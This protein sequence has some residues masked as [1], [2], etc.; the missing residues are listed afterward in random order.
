MTARK[1]L[2]VLA[3]MTTLVLSVCVLLLV[4]PW[5]DY[6][7]L[8]MNS[9]FHPDQRA[10]NFR[11]MERIFPSRVIAASTT[12][13][14]FARDEKPLAV[15]YRF[16][17][18]DYTLDDARQRL[19][20]T[21]LLV[22]KDD[23]IVHEG[24]WQGADADS[25]FTSWSVAK[26]FVATL[27]GMALAEGRIRSL[28]DPISD[29][30]P[31]LGRGGYAG[32]PIR[33]VLMMSSGVKFDETYGRRSSD[34]NRFFMKVFALGQRADRLVA[35]YPRE[36]ASGEVFHY[37]STDTHALAMLLRQ[38]YDQPLSTLLQQR[39]W[40]PLGME[41]EAHWSIDRDSAEGVEL[42]FCCLNAR[43]RDFAKLGRLYLNHGRWNNVQ[44]LPESWV[45]EA[46]VPQGRAW[47]PG[48]SPYDYGPRGYGYQW[49]M[50]DNAQGEYFAAGVWGQYVYVSEPDRLIIARAS[51]DPDFRPNL[52]ESIAVFR[53][54]RDA[55]R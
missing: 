2:A 17:E 32:V 43:L 46:T 49:W 22:I 51:V 35:G 54:I 33:H 25:R 30:V 24:Y 21:G 34:I 9:L 52:P 15:R 45:R 8:R 36:R 38:L 39:L 23:R 13:F 31:A 50:P 5:S 55:L 26:S 18:R 19:Q 47:E 1:R 53:A 27:V 4:R 28:D 6:P 44:L 40:Q 37:I 3:V 10:R 20:M 42:G 7:P 14:V 12:P 16:D 41:G 29:Y 48:V 11:Q